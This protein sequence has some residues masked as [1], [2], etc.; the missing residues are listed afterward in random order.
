MIISSIILASSTKDPSEI[1]DERPFSWHKSLS[2]LFSLNA[3]ADDLIAGKEIKLYHII[4]IYIFSKKGEVMTSLILFIFLFIIQP[5]LSHTIPP[6]AL[7]KTPTGYCPIQD[8]NE[9]DPVTSCDENNN[10]ESTSYVIN[11]HLVAHDMMLEIAV[12]DNLMYCLIQAPE[13]VYDKRS[14]ITQHCFEEIKQKIADEYD[15]TPDSVTL[16]LYDLP[17]SDILLTLHPHHNFYIK[18]ENGDHLCHNWGVALPIISCS[19]A[20]GWSF[21]GIAASAFT[22]ASLLAV[23]ITVAIQ[24]VTSK[25]IDHLNEKQHPNEAYPSELACASITPDQFIP[26]KPTAHFSQAHK[27]M[28]VDHDE[29]RTTG[30]AGIPQPDPALDKNEGCF[31]PVEEKTPICILPIEQPKED[32]KTG[33]FDTTEAQ[34][35]IFHIQEIG[36]ENIQKPVVPQNEE[37]SGS[38]SSDNELIQKQPDPISNTAH[39]VNAQDALQRKMKA[40]QGAQKKATLIKKID[41]NRIRYYMPERKSHTHGTTRG[42]SYVVEHNIQTGQVRSWNECYDHDGN[43][44]RVHPKTINGQNI[45]GKHYPPTKSEL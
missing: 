2:A 15:C 33:C 11:K 4:T 22:P 28:V 24:I 7:I 14:W 32:K 31:L 27:K 1:L 43:V 13:T 20:T 9:N 12:E 39:N 35:P 38:K 10:Q 34:T 19:A 45:K 29:K 41:N 26:Q 44:N 16:D 40:L 5:L 21:F 37:I 18:S 23:V 8:L 3:Y 36:K 6:T 30:C 17:E 25:I 42:A